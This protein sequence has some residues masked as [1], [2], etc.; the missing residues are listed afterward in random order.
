MIGLVAALL[1]GSLVSDAKTDA[2]YGWDTQVNCAAVDAHVAGLDPYYVKN[3]KDTN[4]SYPY[5]PVTLDVLR[6][7]C[8]G[9]LLLPHYRGL[10]LAIALLCGL[11]LP[12][13]DAGRS[14]LRDVALRVLF[15]VG[16]FL[17]FEWTLASGNFVIFTGLLTA[18]SL[19]LLLPSGLPAAQ[20]ELAFPPRMIGAALLGL[21]LSF[22]L[23]FFPIVASLYLLP[24]PRP[25]KITLIAIAA[26]M[27]AL[28]IL[29]SMTFYADLF[30]SWLSAI[31]G[32]IAG[33]HSV[34]FDERT[35]S[36][37][38]L[39]LDLAKRLG[40]ADARPLAFALYAVCV[41]GILTPLIM[42]VVRSMGGYGTSSRMSFPMRLDCWLIEH[43][44]EATRLTAISMYALYLCSP[45]LKEY[46]FFELAIYAAVLIAGLRS[47]AIAIILVCAIG[48]PAIASILGNAF[49]DGF[50]PLS[51]AIIFFG[52]V[53][54]DFGAL[55]NP[56]YGDEG[57]PAS[58][59]EPHDK[60][61]LSQG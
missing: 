11:L 46:A 34:A 21:L 38:V 26:A 3:L 28:P 27:F 53:L 54:L 19:A 35:P 13:I 33:Q 5:L 15:T 4:Y 60:A 58:L 9:G 6:P 23:I 7:I 55:K 14:T 25:R 43:P 2:K 49:M 61:C 42:T 50:G 18:V 47:A 36:F 31:S 32:Q 51:A 56:G 12:G 40:P 39:S 16:G 8:A 20:N 57:E 1:F 29:V 41:L 22:K 44:R 48:L 45:R 17:G 37:F 24:L 30:H 52:T 10:F 59:V